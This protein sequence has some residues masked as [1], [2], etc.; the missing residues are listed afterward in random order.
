VL[1]VLLCKRCCHA[2]SVECRFDIRGASAT[3]SLYCVV[4]DSAMRK[5]AQQGLAT[6]PPVCSMP[7]MTA[8]CTQA[9]SN[10]VK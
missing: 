9:L 6:M 1:A 7:T 8:E 4:V 5:L 10:T 3:A 2:H